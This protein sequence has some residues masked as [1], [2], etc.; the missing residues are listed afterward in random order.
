MSDASRR[1]F[2]EHHQAL[3]D[4]QSLRAELK[5]VSVAIGGATAGMLLV[6]Q[7]ICYSLSLP[8]QYH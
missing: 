7:E 6:I 8:F 2:E 4:D 5:V 1:D 3:V